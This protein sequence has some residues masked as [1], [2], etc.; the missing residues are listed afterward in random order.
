MLLKFKYHFIEKHK[1]TLKKIFP[2]FILASLSS[3]FAKLEKI[4]VS[5]KDVFISDKLK[6]SVFK[7]YTNDIKKLEQLLNCK[8]PW[9]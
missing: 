1:K 2:K 7:D 9:R 8:V 6:M 3:L 5:K 4:N